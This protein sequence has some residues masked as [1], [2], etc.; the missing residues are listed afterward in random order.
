MS[1]V[2]RTRDWRAKNVLFIVSFP[3]RETALKWIEDTFRSDGAEEPVSPVAVG[4]WQVGRRPIFE[5]KPID[6]GNA[7]PDNPGGLPDTADLEFGVVL[8]ADAVP[9]Y[10][11]KRDDGT[12][13]VC[14]DATVDYALKP[15]PATEEPPLA[16]DQHL[17]E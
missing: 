15:E 14:V 3:D 9:N 4:V 8:V 7:N 17:G 1:E 16:V 11:E 10:I 2:A 13:W 6:L 5:G 12:F